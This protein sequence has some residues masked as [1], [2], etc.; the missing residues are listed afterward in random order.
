MEDFENAVEDSSKALELLD[1]PVEANAAAR[2]KAFI[3]LDLKCQVSNSTLAS[4]IEAERI[5]S[6]KTATNFGY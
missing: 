5:T 2:A 6:I 3:R 1:P 4:F